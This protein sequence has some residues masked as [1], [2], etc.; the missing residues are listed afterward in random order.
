MQNTTGVSPPND[1]RPVPLDPRARPV[2]TGIAPDS[3]EW[4][5]QWVGF[6]DEAGPPPGRFIGFGDE[7][8]RPA[9]PLPDRADTG[10][11]SQTPGIALRPAFG[12]L[13]P[14]AGI[15]VPAARRFVRRRPAAAAAAR[16]QRQ[17]FLTILCL[18]LLGYALS[19]KSAAY[20]GLRLSRKTAFT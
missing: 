6:G 17:A 13:P 12:E 10:L 7:D 15:A 3:A 18:L 11:P 1:L 9:P 8:L 14:S 4:A 16:P 19:G 20:L 5:P 2:L